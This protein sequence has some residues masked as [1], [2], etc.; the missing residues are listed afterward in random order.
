MANTQKVRLNKFIADCG[1][2]SRRKAD[3]LIE[4][5]LIQ[6]NG[7]KVYELGAKVDPA[8]DLVTYKGQRLMQETKKVY[9]AFYKPRNVVTT[10][11]DPLGRPHISDYFTKFPLRVFPVGRL[12]WDTEGLILL[13]NDGEFSQKVTHPK[14]DV[15]KTYLVKLDRHI[16][17]DKLE[18]L[19]TGVTLP[20][21]KAVALYAG[22]M[23]SKGS[24]TKDW[25][26]LIITEGR[27]R[28][29][30]NMFEKIG[31]DVQKLKRVAIGQLSLG[32]MKPGEFKVLGDASLKAIFQPDKA[33]LAPTK[34]SIPRKT[35]PKRGQIKKVSAKKLFQKGTR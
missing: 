13:S 26:K 1:I 27:N 15:T 33:T 22:R 14:N 5:G 17:D 6:V 21:G 11:N 10:M 24:K 4:E 20:G 9:L 32:S 34:A 12:D 8:H 18:K 3:Q 19:K 28:Q 2:A 7:K 23:S 35:S 31:Y 16:T 30:R 25:V 29:V